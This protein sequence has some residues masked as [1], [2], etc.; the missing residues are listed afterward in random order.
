MPEFLRPFSGIFICYRRD[1]SAAHAG[2]LFDT[3]AD[4]F[5]R[6]RI[7]MGIDTIEPGEDFVKVIENAVGSCDILIALIGPNWVSPNALDNPIDLVRLEIA[8]ANRLYIPVIP[9]LVNGAGVPRDLPFGLLTRIVVELTNRRWQHDVAK[10]ID[11]LE[12]TLAK[13]EEPVRQRQ[14]EEEKHLREVKQEFEERQAKHR[15]LEERK[16]AEET[17]RREA[18]ERLRLEAQKTARQAEDKRHREGSSSISPGSAAP[19]SPSSSPSP[20]RDVRP[21]APQ[22]RPRSGGLVFLC[23]ARADQ[24]FA[25][26]LAQALKERGIRVW[27]DQWDIQPRDDWDT[28][29]DHALYG[30]ECLLIVLSPASVA[31]EEVKAELRVA[32]DEKKSVLPILYQKCRVPRR[33]KLIQN[34]DFTARDPEDEAIIWRLVD[35]LNRNKE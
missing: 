14:E 30:C 24:D 15:A 35:C 10:L 1:D 20:A 28:S 3:L 27:V 22:Q 18:E 5:G 21:S 34:F 11:R 4:H 25:L 9:V 26:P 23:Y 17:E 12:R 16:E 33:L 7:F 19:Y 2:R 8:T 32:L 6:D 13:G 31:S 29:I